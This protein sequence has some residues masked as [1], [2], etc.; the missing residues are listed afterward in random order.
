MRIADMN[1]MQVEARV[2]HD[3]RCVL[4][5]GSVEQH[6]Y[7]S[8]CVDMI[9]SEKV[10]VDA[11]EPLGVP[12]YP[13]VPF[14][15]TP[16]FADFPGTVTLRLSTYAALIEDILESLYQSGFRRIV[17][18]NG[19][20]GNGPIQGFFKEWMGRRRDARVKLHNWWNAPKTWAKV[21]AIDP[22]ASHASWMENFPWT[23]VPGV[24]P[25]Q[26]AKPAIDMRRMQTANPAEV[27][28]LIGDGNFHGRYERPDDEV[29]ALWQVAVEETRTIIE[30][31]WP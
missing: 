12:V 2:K 9:L 7:L 20:G 24:K 11:A 17:V 8:L 29:L 25:P 26:A 14:G 16:Y 21:Q 27:R 4:P 3:D 13:A 1:W 5:I 15:L 19:H 30:E 28:A 18:V 22:A 10:A 6:A 23:R 31:D